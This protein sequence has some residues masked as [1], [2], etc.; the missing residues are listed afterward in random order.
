MRAEPVEVRDTSFD[1]LR[2]HTPS[3]WLLGVGALLATLAFEFDQSWVGLLVAVA[4]LVGTFAA[5]SHW[6]RAAGWTPRHLLMVVGGA[7]LAR[8]LEGFLIDPI[9]DGSDVAKYIHNTVAVL[10]V[11]VLVAIGWWRNPSTRPFDKLRTS[12]S[13]SSG[14]IMESPR[15]TR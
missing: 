10:L 14:H 8:A 12:P 13:T 2:T 15:L 11:V 7:M 4:V 3:P 1:K 9:G 6:S 5:L